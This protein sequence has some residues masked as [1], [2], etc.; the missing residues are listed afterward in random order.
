M[1]ILMA[2]NGDADGGNVHGEDDGSHIVLV[3][4]VLLSCSLLNTWSAAFSDSEW[5]LRRPVHA[6]LVHPRAD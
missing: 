1:M 6:L 5:Q 2:M 3:D 4:K